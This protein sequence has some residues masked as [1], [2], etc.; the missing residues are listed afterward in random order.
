MADHHHPRL[1]GPPKLPI[2][3]MRLESTFLRNIRSFVHTT[4]AGTRIEWGKV[5][6]VAIRDTVLSPLLL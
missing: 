2:P 6:W 3:D 1:H 5:A 4:D